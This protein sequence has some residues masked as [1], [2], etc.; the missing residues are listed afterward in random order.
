MSEPHP[1]IPIIG[2]NGVEGALLRSHEATECA[3]PYCAIHNPSEHPLRYAP[4]QW[5][6]DL[7]MLE[8]VCQHGFG[9]PDVDNL[10]YIFQMFGETAAAHASVHTCDGCCGLFAAGDPAET[11]PGHG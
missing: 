6:N 3:L 11:R 10:D 5:R 1:E 9:H 2:E 4:Q 8:R 7:R